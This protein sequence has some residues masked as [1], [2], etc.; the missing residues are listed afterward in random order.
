MGFYGNISNTSKSSFQF[1]RTYANKRDMDNGAGLGDGV[2]PGRFVLVD[3]NYPTNGNFY[4]YKNG[5]EQDDIYWFYDG[6]LHAGSPHMIEMGENLLYG[7]PEDETTLV[8]PQNSSL[9]VGSMVMIPVGRRVGHLNTTSEYFKV[10]RVKTEGRYDISFE[11]AQSYNKWLDEYVVEKLRAQSTEEL[12]EAQIEEA[13]RLTYKEITLTQKTYEP[14]T[15][16]VTTTIEVPGVDADGYDA[17]IPKTVFV[18]DSK[19][20]F[21]VNTTYYHRTEQEI[22]DE[23][24]PAF[25]IFLTTSTRNTDGWKY[26]EDFIVSTTP[27]EF[28]HHYRIPK[29]QKYYLN[30]L[31][32]FW[33]VAAISDGKFVWKA[34]VE[35]VNSTDNYFKNMSIDR[36][37]VSQFG[38]DSSGLST[39]GYDS[40]VWQKVVQNG[41][42][43]YVMV[44]ELNSVV[45]TFDIAFDAPTAIPMIPHFD[46]DSTNV[47][48]KLHT[49]PQW[50]FRTKAAEIVRG[51]K[52]DSAGGL[53]GSVTLSEDKIIYPSDQSTKWKSDFYNTFTGESSIQYFNPLQSNWTSIDNDNNQ[54]K[55]AIYFNK[56]GFL[57]KEISYSAD[58]IDNKQ[59]GYNETI[60]KSGWKNNDR[61][62]IQPTGL[63]GQLYKPHK[64]GLETT[65]QV[66]TQ[67]LSI[68]L[69]SLGDTISSIWDIVFGGRNTNE[70]INRTGIRNMDYQWEDAKAVIERGGLRL[71]DY[72][73][74]N[75][76]NTAQVNTLAG[77]INSAHDLMGMIVTSD[78][79]TKLKENLQALDKDR[80]YYVVDD[81]KNALGKDLNNTYTMMRKIYTY[82]EKIDLE[83]DYI[84]DDGMITYE[85]DNGELKKPVSHYVYDEKIEGYREANLEDYDKIGQ[86]LFYKKVKKMTNPLTFETITLTNWD[87]QAW[88]Y[89]DINSSPYGKDEHGNPILEKQDYITNKGYEKEKKYF[90][91]VNVEPDEE[92]GIP[93]CRVSLNGAYEPGKYYYEENNKYL[94]DYNENSSL[95]KKYLILNKKLVYNVKDYYDGIYI[96]GL[97][98]YYDA[99]TES[100]IRDMSVDGTLNGKRNVHY[101]VKIKDKVDENP[102]YVKEVR[103]IPVNGED[104]NEIMNNVIILFNTSNYV[105]YKD[106]NGSGYVDDVGEY[107][108]VLISSIEQITVDKK[109]A[110]QQIVYV[111]AQGQVEID[112]DNQLNLT[113]YKK[114]TFFMEEYDVTGK[115][116]GYIPLDISRIDPTN[117]DQQFFAFGKWEKEEDWQKNG[118]SPF[119]AAVYGSELEQYY[120]RLTWAWQTQSAFYTPHI[121]HYKTKDG[122]Y[123][124]DNSETMKHD[125]YYLLT[126]NN[127]EDADFE[128]DIFFEKDEYY[129]YNPITGEY[130]ILTE[131][132]V[133]FDENGNLVD[134]NNQPIQVYHADKIYVQEDTAGVYEEGCEWNL[135]DIIVPESVTLAKRGYKWDLVPLEGFAEKLNTM[136]GL[137]L[138]VNDVLLSGDKLTRDESTVQGALNKIK[139][140]LVRLE[141][142]SPEKFIIVDE[143][144]KLR[145]V[146]WDTV[147]TESINR[148]KLTEDYYLT[149]VNEDKFPERSYDTLNEKHE[150]ARNQW[151]T[152]NVDG[153]VLNPKIRIHHNFQSVENTDGSTDLNTV[154]AS[155]NFIIKTPYVDAAGHV[156]GEHV[157]NY[158]LPFSFKTFNV[159]GTSDGVT[160]LTSTTNISVVADN[161][162]DTMTLITHNKWIDIKADAENDTITFG[163]RLTG[164]SENQNKDFGLSTDMTSAQ[165]DSNTNKFN[166]PVFRF[167]QAGHIIKAETHTISLPDNFV[168]FKNTLSS[169]DNADSLTGAVVDI[170]PDDMHDILTFAEGNKWINISGNNTSKTYTISHY[171][172]NFTQTTST[173]DFNT[174][175]NGKTFTVQTIGWDRAGHIISSDKKTFTLPDNFKNLAVTNTGSAVVNLGSA[176]P[177]T[178]VADNLVDTATFD[179]GNRWITLAA[180]TTNDKITFYH[181]APDASSASTN[182]TVTGD[183][184]PNFGATFSIPEVKYDETGHI[185]KVGTHTVKIPKP[186]L[187][188]DNTGNVMTGLSLTDTTGA[189]T[190][191][192]ENLSSLL[193]TGYTKGTSANAIAATDTLGGALSKL[194]TQIDTEVSTRSTLRTEFDV[195]NGANTV[196]GSVKKQIKDAVEALDVTDTAV[197]KQFVSAVSE[198]DGK[199]TV[200]RR[201]LVAEDFC[202]LSS[203]TSMPYSAPSGTNFDNQAKTIAWLFKKVYSL[204]QRIKALEEA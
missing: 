55:A 63:S 8:T 28:D 79:S 72:R 165:V 83:I 20:K 158:T 152:V 134:S 6:N 157:E 49:Q 141:K 103:Y 132:D 149:G 138:K 176:T 204:E 133:N 119:M 5:L 164:I 84:I 74:D 98:Y 2:Y 127:I 80:I 161:T 124:L 17:M 85:V 125:E 70:A 123:I 120:N 65:P 82:D 13:L 186:S 150:E 181:A 118:N 194:Q 188:N 50:G 135:N 12:T 192:K 145:S 76:Y 143:Y 106:Y 73:N 45:P 18:L 16:F 7:L 77:C 115:L 167:D 166:V 105:Y 81:R 162:I 117:K 148:Q 96:P 191:T 130:T 78:T 178:I 168:S 3:Y 26:G 198:T 41:V 69:P 170:T 147:Q 37:Y 19:N 154:G 4:E 68:M 151:I 29:F 10:T 75:L 47:Y 30:Y 36:A 89:Q 61:I 32:E 139:D 101:S 1:D 102:S 23:E 140:I 56:K 159:T 24:N 11:T 100:Y 27:L 185:F 44:A 122:C 64:N 86:I 91:I 40:T 22:I 180:D 174:I 131:D 187:T 114:N 126:K 146:D 111:P 160:G 92:K 109:Y 128:D 169:T 163:H 34:V 94:I 112:T 90:K 144:G 54:I 71:V 97:Y 59:K 189:F 15:F 184:T 58:L 42:D 155:D 62:D 202:D 25:N 87:P 153:N 129:V 116:I 113:P 196:E 88:W 95:N 183:E 193:L 48:Y 38:T 199:I 110:V 67:E 200:A 46:K 31:V 197:A 33:Q 179:A 107:N 175:S 52:I 171:V 195:L 173:L 136:H 142:L 66:D 203:T 137:I 57:P 60:A 156:V 190:I 9:D 108:Y 201:A 99:T 93:G 182:T 121:Y 104:E 172:K 177:G 39:R 21:D 51:P 53:T 14:N 43:K 35:D